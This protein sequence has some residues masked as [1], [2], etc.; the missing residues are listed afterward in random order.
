MKTTILAKMVGIVRSAALTEMGEAAEQI[1]QANLGYE[2]ERH[3]ENFSEP[4]M[5]FYGRSSYDVHSDHNHRPHFH[6]RYGRSTRRRSVIETGAPLAGVPTKCVIDWLEGFLLD[7]HL[8]AGDSEPPRASGQVVRRASGVWSIRALRLRSVPV[9][10][11][12]SCT[13]GAELQADWELAT[14]ES[15]AALASI[16]PSHE[17]SPNP[18][19]HHKRPVVEA[20]RVNGARRLGWTM[21]GSSL[22]ICC[23]S[24]ATHAEPD[25]SARDRP[26][27]AEKDCRG[28]HDHGSRAL[29]GR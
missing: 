6:A 2:K 7:S 3:P 12:R 8:R 21:N 18:P 10:D 25:H 1:A 29:A 9:P 22:T 5:R 11:A 27:P 26:L 28:P 15:R 19:T 13:R 17:P 4:L 23:L 20:T 14:G 24:S 16:E